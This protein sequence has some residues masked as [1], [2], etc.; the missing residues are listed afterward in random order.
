M[1]Y[2]EM[3][4]MAAKEIKSVMEAVKRGQSN[5]WSEGHSSGFCDAIDLMYPE[6]VEQNGNAFDVAKR[7]AIN[8]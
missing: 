2:E 1:T 4:N 3:I 8:S 5:S 6:M 7:I